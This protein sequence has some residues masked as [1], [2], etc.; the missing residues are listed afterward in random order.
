MLRLIST[1]RMAARHGQSNWRLLGVLAAGIL[2]SAVLLASAPIYSRAM[3]DLGLTF[4]IREELDGS[5]G[6]T[7]EVPD[8]QLQTDDGS[9]V[10]SSI[11]AR[12]DER[13][14]WFRESQTRALELPRLRYAKPNEAMVNAAPALHLVSQ[15]GYESHVTVVEGKLPGASKPGT[16]IETAM[17]SAIASSL[18]LTVGSTYDM[19]EDFDT[20]ERD[21]PEGD[22][23]PPP[24]PCDF[25]A[26]VK[27][28]I[29]AV[30]VGII[31]P[32][33]LE[34]PIW[35]AGSGRLFAPQRALQIP[36]EGPNL[37]VWVSEA[38]IVEGFGGVYPGYYTLNRWSVFADPELLNRRNYQRATADIQGLSDEI[39]EVDGFTFGPLESTLE[40]FGT[41]AEFA[42]T[43]LTILLL[44]IAGVALFYTALVAAT[45]VERQGQEITLFRSR[46]ASTWQIASIYLL[47][48]LYLAIPIIIIAPFLAAAATALLGFTPLFDDVSNGDLL[49]VSIA[50]SAFGMA[51]I[52][53]VLG[54]AALI[55]PVIVVAGRGAL[56]HRRGMAR[57]G[58][59]FIQRYYIDLVFAALAGL[60][61][62]ELNQK[63]SAF[64][65]SATGGVSSDP[66]LLASPALIIA[67]AAALILRFYPIVLRFAARA[68]SVA[69]AFT[70]TMSI[71]QLSRSP[72]Q[73]TRL[74]LLL[75]MAIAVG[76]YAASYSSTTERSFEDR[77][78]FD[79]PVDMRSFS[80]GRGTTTG[81]AAVI[82]ATAEE[83]PGVENAS[84]VFRTNNAE[85]ATPG[86]GGMRFQALGLDPG[87]TGD[88][89]WFRDDFANVP[90]DD[91]LI[92]LDGPANLAGK[93]LPGVPATLSAWVNPSPDVAQTTMR[94]RFLDSDNTPWTADFGPVGNAGWHELTTTIGG[95]GGLREYSPPFRL[96]SFEVYEPPNARR[97]SQKPIAIDDISVSDASGTSTVVET[98]EAAS[99]WA[100]LPQRTQLAD[101]FVLK[102]D[103]PHGGRQYGEFTY[104]AAQ[105]QS[106]AQG[107]YVVDALAPLGVVVSRSFSNST[108]LLPGTRGLVIVNE[109]VVPI[110][111]LANYDLFP[112]LPGSLGPSIIFN[113]DQILSWVNTFSLSPNTFANEIWF[114]LEPGVDRPQLAGLVFAEYGFDRWVDLDESLRQVRSNPLIVPGGSGI[115]VVAFL[116]VLGLVGA[117]MLVSLWTAVHRRR[118]EFAVMR[119]LGTSRGQVFRVLTLEY[120]VVIV[121]GLV[122]GAYLG[123]FVARRMLSFLNVTEGGRRVEPAFILQTD[124]VFVGASCGVVLI[125]FAAA[126]LFAVRQLARITDA[127]ALRTE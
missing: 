103:T 8:I 114:D 29:P 85:M 4:T 37:A 26:I 78:N 91:L 123:L 17:S 92:Q 90:V 44:E 74:A 20:C 94:A 66:V 97:G 31:E 2:V 102:T 42:Q 84:P 3:A 22:S 61:L 63:G 54:V 59:S 62:W 46:G 32:V 18:G 67:A 30:L 109:M 119:A 83:M 52:G 28:R 23:P 104:S 65:P 93:T 6:A 88:M 21:I 118:V 50:P 25:K 55:L 117:A 106:T 49:P 60:L 34:A 86:G 122:G 41:A 47:E 1:W 33:D 105:T 124:W 89:L 95:V 13:L 38:T 82:E 69:K 9:A 107:F 5:A 16:P 111:V 11:E 64:E 14:G 108:G 45:V 110:T 99:G 53:A 80:E 101:A 68:I 73:Y 48:G 96:I 125:V 43:P 76:T 27:W 19:L 51:A 12:I 72:G 121:I 75:M 35:F 126:L 58:S 36:G 15:T 81:A 56:A 98:F 79:A 87:E 116:A 24:P 10:R 120:L 112:T 40:G 39:Q 113:R 71:W 57:P 70:L 77:A 7:V 115:L 100:P 127:Q